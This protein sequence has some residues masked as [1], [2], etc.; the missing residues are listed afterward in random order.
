MGSDRINHF[1]WQK[2]EEEDPELCPAFFDFYRRIDDTIGELLK[3]LPEDVPLLVFSDHGFCSI[4]QEVQ[5]S[6]YLI[7]TG[8][9]VPTDNPQHPLCIDP[10]KSRA[11][12]LIPG[13]I[14]INLAGREPQGIVPVEAYQQV[15]DALIS[16][17]M[18]LHAPDT[19]DAVI[20][21]VVPREQ[22]YWPEGH[23]HCV[24]WSPAQVAQAGGTFGK[25]ADL[26]AIP[27]D[28]Y[29]LK[30]GLKEQTVFKRTALEGMHTYDDAFMVARGID[31]PEG[32]LEI[33]MLART[34]L[35][36]MGVAPPTDMDGSH[37]AVTPVF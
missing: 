8:W 32:D 27:H 1:L 6:R 10:T 35:T 23:G 20:R 25:A 16:D 14:F 13:R 3:R 11:Y 15:R 19:G 4:K 36:Q 33:M 28:G 5:L 26:T 7:E 22:M 9:T 30:L 21:T 17:L 37:D 31:L 24:D 18:A 12:C 29:D 34:I 2:M